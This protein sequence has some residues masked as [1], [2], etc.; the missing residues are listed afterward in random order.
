MGSIHNDQFSHDFHRFVLQGS[1]WVV[2]G[3]Q[4]LPKKPFTV[5]PPEKSKKTKKDCDK[6]GNEA[7][8]QRLK[9]PFE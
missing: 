1:P 2:S 3:S 5:A 7:D 8:D 6:R 4:P 9:R